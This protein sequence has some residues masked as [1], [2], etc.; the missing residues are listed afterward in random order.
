MVVVL[1]HGGNRFDDDIFEH[2]LHE[3]PELAAAPHTGLVKID[4]DWMK[5]KAGKE[6]WRAFINAC[7]IS[8]RAPF[9]STL[10]LLIA[11]SQYSRSFSYPRV[12]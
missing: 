10:R 9:I 12:L 11:Q 8:L 6:R 4:E 1:T 2:T 3:F 5:S 7:V